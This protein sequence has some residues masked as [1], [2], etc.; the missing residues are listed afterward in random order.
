MVA[1]NYTKFESVD[2]YYH[3]ELRYKIAEL[4][5]KNKRLEEL[6]LR[7]RICTTCGK[8]LSQAEANSVHTCYYEK[9]TKNVD[10]TIS[11]Q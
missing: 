4:L 2:A 11:N 3:R 10:N 6:I 9:E 1:E 8:Q 7:Y 5:A